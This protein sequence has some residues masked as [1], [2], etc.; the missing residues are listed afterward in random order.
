MRE[1]TCELVSK[2]F[3]RKKLAS[4]NC[5]SG[6]SFSDSHPI[7]II[8]EWRKASRCCI[9]AVVSRG[10]EPA[11]RKQYPRRCEDQRGDSDG[12]KT[13]SALCRRHRE[14]WKIQ[15]IRKC[16]SARCITCQCNRVNPDNYVRRRLTISS[17]HSS[18]RELRTRTHPDARSNHVTLPVSASSFAP[19]LFYGNLVWSR[20]KS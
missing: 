5:L 12:A 17:V 8:T 19:S 4:W 11:V 2:L 14:I 9:S 16:G 1:M 18:E 20:R 7:A 6:K 3:A 13:R 15:E 10:E